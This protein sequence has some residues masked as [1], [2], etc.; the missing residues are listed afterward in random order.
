MA[1]K[2]IEATD[3]ICVVNPPV[4]IYGQPYTGKTTLA[5]TAENVVTLDFDGGIQRA[6]GRK[7]V[8]RREGPGGMPLPLEWADAIEAEKA[9]Q[10]VRFRSVA[11]D[12][13]GKMVDSLIR[14]VVTESAKNGNIESG[15]NRAGWGIV[16]NRFAS[17]VSRLR[18]AGLQPVF[19]CHEKAT[20]TDEEG[21]LRPAITGGAASLVMEMCDIVGYMHIVGG[22]RVIDFNPTE[23]RFAKNPAGWP[24]MEVP[25]V[26]QRPNLLAELIADACAKMSAVSEESNKVIHEVQSVRAFLDGLPD[27]SRVTAFIAEEVNTLSSPAQKQVKPLVAR[28]AKDRRWVWDKAVSRYVAPNSVEME[29]A[30]AL[31][32][33]GD[34]GQGGHDE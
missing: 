9:G 4:L 30:A 16:K 8:L 18:A 15:P 7:P 1:A 26:A 20:G 10:F 19:V 32:A 29:K 27:V 24:A 13:V 31:L 2:L 3:T 5:Q 28:Y 25:N 34:D 12:T 6:A 14:A 21:K 17:W 11:V 33:V 22:K 23:Q